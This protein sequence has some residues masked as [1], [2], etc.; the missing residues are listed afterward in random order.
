MFDLYSAKHEVV[1][2]PVPNRIAVVLHLCG[3]YSDER[4]ALQYLSGL[5]QLHIEVWA[6]AP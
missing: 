3:V 4:R 6:M 2:N 1:K 5:R